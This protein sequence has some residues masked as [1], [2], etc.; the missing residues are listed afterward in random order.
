[1]MLNKS[2]PKVEFFLIV[3]K[4]F[5]ILMLGICFFPL[6][7]CQTE[8][9]ILHGNISGIITDAITGLPLQSAI[10]SITSSDI[11]VVSGAN[12]SY[13]LKNLTPGGYEITVRKSGYGA[14]TEFVNAGEAKTQMIDFPLNPLPVIS[15]PGLDFGSDST[16]KSFTI[17][18]PYSVRLSYVISTSQDWI[19]VLPLSGEFTNETEKIS[20]KINRTGLP[21]TIFKEN[22]IIAVYDRK[23]KIGDIP[24]G[25]YL[26]GL[27]D[28]DGNYYRIV[29]IGDQ[30][31]MAENLNTG[32]L[33]DPLKDQTDNGIIEKYQIIYEY[34]G[35]YQWNEMMQYGPS[36]NKIVGTTQGICPVGWHIPTYNEWI[37][38]IN[39]AGKSSVAAGKLKESGHTH[40]RSGNN[41]SDPGALESTDEF[42]FTAL[43]GG[44]RILNGSFIRQRS[45]G[46]WWS[47]A[48]DNSTASTYIGMTYENR[49]ITFTYSLPKSKKAGYSVRCVKNPG[50]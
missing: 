7:G 3:L 40:W 48:E 44:G 43:P 12:G 10:V 31:W 4:R 17:S 25:I 21:G 33:I 16:S 27:M 39:F 26:N 29:N 47:S 35:L 37:T 23:G 20:V 15:V 38:L 24:V 8:E 45:W 5:K 32:I 34:G 22:L 13:L 2:I 1:M 9:I 28:Q 6:S 41:P 11:S 42:G 50:K 19:D 36:D 49:M 14:F 30:T 46:A 18:N